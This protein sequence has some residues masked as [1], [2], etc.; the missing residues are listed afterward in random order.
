VGWENHDARSN[1]LITKMLGTRAL[2]MERRNITAEPLEKNS[3]RSATCSN[4]ILLFF[5]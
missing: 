1:T 5:L 4:L 2:L 3:P